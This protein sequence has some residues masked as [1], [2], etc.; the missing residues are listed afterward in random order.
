MV[1]RNPNMAKLQS[2]YLFPEIARRKNEFI[3]KNPNAKLVS[4]GIGDTTQPIKPH[5]TKGLA[6]EASRLGT[7]E[8]YS[9]YG[10]EQGLEELRD[11]IAEKLYN[12]AINGDEVFVSDGA[13]PDTARLQ[14]LFGSNVSI[15]VQD[16]SYPVYVDSSVILGQ[17]K[18]YN[19]K[20]SQFGGIEYM[21]CVPENNFF[22]DLEKTKKTDIIF[23]CNP[24]NPTGAAAARGQLKQ[25]V[26]FARKNKSILVYDSAYSQFIS[27]KSL[28]KSIYEIEGAEE[29]AIEIS[30]FS[31]PIGFTGVR[32][33]WT[34]IPNELEFEDG[35]KVNKDWNRIMTTLFNGASNIAQRG[36]LAALDKK[37][38]K[39]MEQTVSYYLENAKVIMAS[40]EKLGYE[41]Y[42]GIHAP[43]IWVRVPG[44]TSWQAFEEFLGKANVVTIPGVGFGPSGEGFL[45][46][47]SL[48]NRQDVDEA[49]KRIERSLK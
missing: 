45:R 5:I 24:N 2:G 30:S 36:G 11:R 34:V 46:L 19:Q 13:K 18:G 41:V 20:K 9:G 39:E 28:P 6:D 49:V 7:K 38:M 42:G 23:F 40:M 37:G 4:L 16:P 1:K 12:G 3:K 47:S 22:P 15:A 31:K 33:G 26:E 8:G 29:V 35:T 14:L 27:D 48:G 10:A 25:L 32:L 44:K 21:K 43:Y 17:A